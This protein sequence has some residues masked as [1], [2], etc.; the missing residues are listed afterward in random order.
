MDQESVG[1]ASGSFICTLALT[2]AEARKL[3]SWAS[4]PVPVHSLQKLPILSFLKEA[5]PLPHLFGPMCAVVT[6]RLHLGNLQRADICFSWFWRL[7]SP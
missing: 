6:E 1:Q 5:T 7:E 2:M 3:P 4:E